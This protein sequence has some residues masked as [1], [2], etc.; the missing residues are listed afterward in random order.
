MLTTLLV[1]DRED[2]V[3]RTDPAGDLVIERSGGPAELSSASLLIS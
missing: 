1:A 3:V 2:R